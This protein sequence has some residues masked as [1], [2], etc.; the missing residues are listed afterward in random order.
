MSEAFLLAAGQ[1][2]L[3]SGDNGSHGRAPSAP[4]PRPRTIAD[5]RE[6]QACRPGPLL[7]RSADTPAAAQSCAAR[8]R[9]PPAPPVFAA[10]LRRPSAPLSRPRGFSRSS[11]F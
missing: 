5:K 11:R 8:L 2:R 3:C 10:R 4:S 7:W 1:G 6:P 9:G